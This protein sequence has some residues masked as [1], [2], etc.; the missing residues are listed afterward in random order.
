VLEGAEVS[1]S[2]APG[3]TPFTAKYSG[4]E[5]FKPSV[6]P[7][8]SF[9]ITQVQT[10]TTMDI[11]A[12][13]SGNGTCTITSGTSLYVIESVLSNGATFSNLPT[14]TITFYSNGTAL[15]SPVPL[16]TGEVPPIA[17]FSITPPITESITLIDLRRRFER[18]S[19]G[20]SPTIPFLNVLHS[21]QDQECTILNS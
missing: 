1:I 2:S 6:S 8:V 21:R 3:R 12:C 5:S 13:G 16:D 9:S 15:G 4:D 19:L 11:P 20:F 7:G 17:T 14:G 10:S 18:L